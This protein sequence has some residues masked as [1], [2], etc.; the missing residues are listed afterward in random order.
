M[1]LDE[2]VEQSRAAAA[3]DPA[4]LGSGAH[5]A[6]LRTALESVFG[7]PNAS[8]D[9]VSPGSQGFWERAT[10][11]MT[12]ERPTSVPG[13]ADS[14]VA[15]LT[16]LSLLH[17]CLHARYS[18][19]FGSFE[20]RKRALNSL[21]WPATDRLLNVIEDG[22]ISA[23]G[24]AADPGITNHLADFADLAVEQAARRAGNSGPGPT[25]AS[26]RNQLFFAVEAYA[27]RPDE[28]PSLNIDVRQV[29]TQLVPL[30][31]S[32]KDGTTEDC[33]VV[34]VEVVKAIMASAL[35]S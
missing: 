6:L 3:A 9:W 2:L 7:L 27:L 30:I 13:F 11:Q 25:P 16:A 34:A 32:T 15:K 14:E 33:G 12:L 1:S 8:L 18:T 35:P 31:E 5:L 22:R 26:Q 4:W 19:S 21:L 29:L 24:G 28:L 17:E 23:L 10:R 20:T